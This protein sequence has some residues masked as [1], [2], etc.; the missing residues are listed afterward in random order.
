MKIFYKTHRDIR[1][2]IVA[3]VLLTLREFAHPVP[4]ADK[5][6]GIV[7]RPSLSLPTVVL[8]LCGLYPCNEDEVDKLFFSSWSWYLKLKDMEIA[9]ARKTYRLIFDLIQQAEN[10]KEISDEN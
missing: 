1:H 6:A 2:I 3:S 10:L 4:S 7:T 5:L 9:D 8:W